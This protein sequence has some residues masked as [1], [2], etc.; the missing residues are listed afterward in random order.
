MATLKVAPVVLTLP[1]LSVTTTC[2]AAWPSGSAPSSVEGSVAVQRPVSSTTAV[3]RWPAK[4]TIIDETFSAL[5]TTPLMVWLTVLSAKLIRLSVPTS[6]WLTTG[7]SVSA[8]LISIILFVTLPKASVTLSCTCSVLS[9]MPCQRLGGKS[10]EMR[11]SPP[12]SAF[13]GMLTSVPT[14]VAVTVAPR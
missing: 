12:T 4:L 14:S 9:T 1:A 7:T 11:P 5:L 13:S 3:R 2:N 10:T 8:R 6:T